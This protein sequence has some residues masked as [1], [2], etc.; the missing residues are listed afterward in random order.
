M[1]L[2]KNYKF[3]YFSRLKS[4]LLLIIFLLNLGCTDSEVKELRLEHQDARVTVDLCLNIECPISDDPCMQDG[5]CDPSSG[6]CIFEQKSN[7]SFCDDG[8]QCT[9]QDR[10]LNGTCMGGTSVTCQPIGQCFTAGVCD[11]T[12]GCSTPAKAEGESCNDADSCTDNDQCDG[13]GQ[14]KG[15]AII[16]EALDECHE[17][18]VCNSATGTCSQPESPDGKDCDGADAVNLCTFGSCIAGECILVDLQCDPVECQAGSCEPSTGICTYVPLADETSCDDQNACT[19]NTTCLAGEC[20]GGTPLQ[21]EYID[22]PNDCIIGRS[23]DENLGCIA[24]YVDDGS[25]CDD[26]NL[27][28]YGDRCESGECVAQEVSCFPPNPG[29]CLNEGTCNPAT[30]SCEYSSKADGS[31]CSENYCFIGQECQQGVCDGGALRTCP[32]AAPCMAFERCDNNQRECIYSILQEGSPCNPERDTCGEGMR[33]AFEE[34]TA[35]GTDRY[36]C[37]HACN[38]RIVCTVNDACHVSSNG[39]EE[40]VVCE[41]EEFT[42]DEPPNDQ[43]YELDRGECDSS[44]ELPRCQYVPRNDGSSCNDGNSCTLN[45]QCQSGDCV[46]G[47]PQQCTSTQCYTEECDG[48]LPE[49]QN[50]V[51]TILSGRTCDNGNFCVETSYCDDDGECVA[52]TQNE[53]NLDPSLF[54]SSCFELQGICQE[55]S[56]NC[57]FKTRAACTNDD[58]CKFSFSQND[59]IDGGMRQLNNI[60]NQQELAPIAVIDLD[61]DGRLDLFMGGISTV[62]TL[63]NNVGLQFYHNQSTPGGAIVFSRSTNFA[64]KVRENI[65]NVSNVQALLVGDMDND[66]DSDLIVLSANISRSMIYFKNV[67]GDQSGPTAPA[68]IA[69]INS[70]Q[71]NTEAPFSGALLDVDNDGDLDMYVASYNSVNHFYENKLDQS[72]PVLIRRSDW[73]PAA[74]TRSTT[75]VALMDVDNDAYPDLVLCNETTT[76]GSQSVEF[77]VHNGENSIEN[78]GTLMTRNNTLIRNDRQKSYCKNISVVDYNFDG[79]LDVYVTRPDENQLF[80]R[81]NANFE[82]RA[83]TLDLMNHSIPSG[84]Y[85]SSCPQIGTTDYPLSYLVSWSSAWGDWDSNGELDLYITHG[86]AVVP[87]SREETFLMD[88]MYVAKARN[89]YEDLIETGKLASDNRSSR[90]VLTA[91]FNQD[92]DLD[93]LVSHLVGQPKMIENLSDQ[94]RFLRLIINGRT[95]NKDAIGSLLTV[96]TKE[97]QVFKRR[98][99]L[100]G[101]NHNGFIGAMPEQ[102]FGLGDN[103]EVDVEV[104]WLLPKPINRRLTQRIL[105]IDTQDPNEPLQEPFKLIE[106]SCELGEVTLTW[107]DNIYSATP[108]P[109]PPIFTDN[110]CSRTEDCTSSLC[111]SNECEVATCN[112]TVKNSDETDVDC[113]GPVCRSCSQ[114]SA[115]LT[116]GDCTAT[117]ICKNQICQAATCNN[118]SKENDESDVDC[119]GNLCAP[120]SIGDECNTPSDCTSNNCDSN[121]NACVLEDNDCSNGVKDGDE[122]DIDCGGSMCNPCIDHQTCLSSSDCESAICSGNPRLCQAHSCHDHIQNGDETAIDCGGSCSP[123]EDGL[124]CEEDDDCLSTHCGSNRTCFKNIGRELQIEFSA[125][126][127][128]NQQG[129]NLVYEVLIEDGQNNFTVELNSSDLQ[130]D[131]IHNGIEET[132][133]SKVVQVSPNATTTRVVSQ[134]LLVDGDTRLLGST[135]QSMAELIR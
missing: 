40:I 68:L 59:L 43:C 8:N 77:V 9:T 131:Q 82:D 55:V 42:C 16:C 90:S 85:F 37:K 134:C 10:C 81:T 24:E 60:R 88:S 127:F 121:N 22:N 67:V 3:I 84:P 135:N 106:P 11:P 125:K 73:L 20:Q 115:C 72:P 5:V 104:R 98:S 71:T 47:T 54:P 105:S 70:L 100:I 17:P 108:A 79:N 4:D 7:G 38:D 122:T 12:T 62:S 74:T 89:S 26:N 80:V 117:D 118:N 57:Y 64:L 35:S 45:D 112:D 91:D 51:K 123:C 52:Q 14:C 53:C 83:E 23:C 92:G 50:C 103:S 27:C 124:S 96:L 1:S 30:G 111:I 86:N 19:E 75:A 130:F 126:R 119:G 31:P 29:S 129:F 95:M 66:S 99:V 21:C 39:N 76:P 120:C 46:P 109:S 41:G 65:G 15:S 93:L 110:E 33:C 114:K 58:L 116:N 6:T 49:D 97:S 101:A 44:G 25:T 78:S 63:D 28:T 132:T 61:K 128:D 36:L 87:S 69:Q 18:G 13:M 107:G 102:H 34:T 113:G 32:E 48:T 2:E 133:V 56:D 94:E